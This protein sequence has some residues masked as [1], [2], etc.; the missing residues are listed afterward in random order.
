MEDLE[1][2]IIILEAHVASLIKT[3]Y[4]QLDINNQTLEKFTKLADRITMLEIII[5]NKVN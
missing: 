5:D 3:T 4:L 1:N 2:K